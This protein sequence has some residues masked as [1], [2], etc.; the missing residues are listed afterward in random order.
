MVWR[1]VLLGLIGLL[2]GA[3]GHTQL[4]IWNS[5]DPAG[6][7]GRPG[8]RLEEPRLNTLLS[9]VGLEPDA[10]ARIDIPDPQGK[11]LSFIVWENTLLPEPLKQKF[12]GI[13]SYSGLL[14]N[15]KRVGLRLE[16]TSLGWYG[17]VY[18]GDQ[19]YYIYPD[20]V[21]GPAVYRV[22]ERSTFEKPPQFDC[23]TEARAAW[24]EGLSNGRPVV[25]PSQH[26]PGLAT[27]SNGN[28][29]RQYRLALA[30]TG[31]YAEAVA[32]PN[33]GVSDVL[34]A[35]VITLNRVNGIYERELSIRFQ[36]VDNND[37]LI[38]LDHTN[39]PYSNSSA[40]AMLTQNQNT[41]STRIGSSNYDIGHV[42]STGG[43]G[44]AILASA[45]DFSSKAK[46]V[47]G[48]SNPTG[49][50]FAVDYVAHEIGHQM[51]ANHTFNA[52]GGN[53]NLQTAFEPGSG[54]TIMAYAGICGANNLQQHSDAYFHSASLGEIVQFIETEGACADQSAGGPP[55]PDVTT[56][57]L[58]Y[59]I[60]A[61]TPFELEGPTGN[62][63]GSDTFL[64]CWEQW[65]LGNL[66]APESGGA[67]Y[68]EGP[69]F[70]S[71]APTGSRS[72]VFPGMENILNNNNSV[73]G[74]RLPRTSRMLNF[75][76]TIRNVVDGLGAFATMDDLAA[77]EVVETGAPFELTYPDNSGL[78]FSPGAAI[79]VT[80][81][82]AG[83]NQ[84]PINCDQVNIFLSEDG[85]QTFPYTLAENVPNTGSASLNLP[86]LVTAQARIKIKASDNIFFDVNN[87]NFTIGNV[88]LAPPDPR[89]TQTLIYPNPAQTA[90]R[91]HHYGD[92]K[93]EITILDLSGKTLWKGNL[94]SQSLSVNTAGW[95]RGMYIVQLK[96]NGGTFAKKLLLQ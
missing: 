36:L 21:A 60:P 57:N 47:T 27:I 26:P 59:V 31:E 94:S 85:G 51:G 66:E 15:D 54:S 39:D 20:Q 11:L 18:K 81:N 87:H 2:Q 70:R 48:M 53:A 35:M 71:F 65:D 69:V 95:A 32:G 55:I 84:S 58:Q 13:R 52:C 79:T 3:T 33:P 29:I 7:A 86:A 67:D 68:I 75:Q 96:E 4:N 73:K 10:G 88:S 91:L 80:W 1:L 83:T 90:V 16:K 9:R 25:V 43:G 89:V 30:C 76:Y 38:F 92:S 24:S 12:P 49:D 44:L 28:I 37:T 34:S 46:G 64:Y 74:E 40:G 50:P 8:F 72:R 6:Y 45:C 77:V 23:K 17:M 42:F 41:I 93:A 82:V 78:N 5:L 56:M 14:E 63:T 22:A 62:N 19:T 61:E